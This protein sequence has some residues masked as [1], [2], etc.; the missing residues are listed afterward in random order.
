MIDILPL[1]NAVFDWQTQYL[2]PLFE[3]ARSHWLVI[4]VIIIVCEELKRWYDNK[5]VTEVS[6]P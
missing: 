6:Q 4:L 3:V 2:I 1:Y 5:E